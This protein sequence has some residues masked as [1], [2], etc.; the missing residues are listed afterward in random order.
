MYLCYLSAPTDGGRLEKLFAG[1]RAARA[2]MA[3]SE[4]GFIKWSED[5]R[6]IPHLR[7]SLVSLALIS[8]PVCSPHPCPFPLCSLSLSFWVPLSH[9]FT[10]AVCFVF[11]PPTSTTWPLILT[12]S[13]SSPGPI[14]HTLL[15]FQSEKRRQAGR[16]WD[17]FF[18]SLHPLSS[19]FSHP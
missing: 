8:P 14:V 1:R 15:P 10:I 3:T 11:F 9:R 4:W 2:G 16:Q 6:C 7:S 12:F 5:I 13:P 17:L 18:S 19:L